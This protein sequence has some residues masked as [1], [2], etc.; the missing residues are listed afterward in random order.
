MYN[1]LYVQFIYVYVQV[2]C[3]SIY[4]LLFIYV[5]PLAYLPYIH[6]CGNTLGL[7]VGSCKKSRINHNL[8]SFYLGLQ[9]YLFLCAAES[10]HRNKV[11]LKSAI[12]SFEDIQIQI[13]TENSY[14]K[15]KI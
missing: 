14:N 4:T 8:S 7:M 15:T 9:T 11:N 2:H 12:N 3:P 6:L 10:P 1:V 5:K 13:I